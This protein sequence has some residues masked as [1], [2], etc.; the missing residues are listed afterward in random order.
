MDHHL[1]R[2]LDADGTWPEFERDWQS[3]CENFGE[4]FSQ[5]AVGSLPVLRDIASK[6]DRDSSVYGLRAEDGSFASVVMVNRTLLPNYT[7]QVLR[8]RHL[9]MSP[10]H[11]FGEH[12]IDDYAAILSRTF[13]RTVHLAFTTMPARHVKFHLRSPADRQFFSSALTALSDFDMFSDVAMR[14]S[15]LYLSLNTAGLSV[16]SGESE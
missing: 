8:V 1:E 9:L 5:Y 16:V 11:D 14:G 6:D 12:T 4:D 13:S 7:G 10:S 2:L 15:W 3:Q